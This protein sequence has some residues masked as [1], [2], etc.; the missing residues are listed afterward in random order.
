MADD[1]QVVLTRDQALV[2]LEWLARSSAAEAPVGFEDQAEQRVLWD[3][4]A[5]LEA[6]LPDSLREDYRTLVQA[7][8]SRVRDSAD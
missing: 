1:I 7:A 2:L 8:R 4:E 6:V 5:L 3:L